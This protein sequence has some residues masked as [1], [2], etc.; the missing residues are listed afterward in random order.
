M[1]IEANIKF[2]SYVCKFYDDNKLTFY[3][4]FLI[5]KYINKFITIILKI[6][7]LNFITDLFE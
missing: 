4:I 1:L 5:V 6:Y 7:V 2:F 3:K